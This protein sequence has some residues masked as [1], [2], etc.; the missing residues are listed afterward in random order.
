MEIWRALRLPNA[1]RLDLRV[2]LDISW[3]PGM[4]EAVVAVMTQ[5]ETWKPGWNNFGQNYVTRIGRV[6]RRATE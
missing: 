5:L 3:P 2:W 1:N 4:K 6:S